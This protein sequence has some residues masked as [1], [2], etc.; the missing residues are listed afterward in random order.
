MGQHDRCRQIVLD[1]YSNTVH[2]QSGEAVTASDAR[3]APHYLE[4]FRQ[5]TSYW[6]TEFGFVEFCGCVLA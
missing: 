1:A 5:A 4:T 3:P 2:V 6:L